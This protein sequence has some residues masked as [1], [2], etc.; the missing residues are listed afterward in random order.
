MMV[1]VMVWLM[2]IEMTT[3]NNLNMIMESIFISLF[4]SDYRLLKESA[5]RALIQTER[6]VS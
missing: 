2:A 3:W 4:P 1:Y 6:I 5:C